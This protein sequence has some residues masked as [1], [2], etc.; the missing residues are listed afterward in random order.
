M[1][2]V[3]P[4]PQSCMYSLS[5]DRF[6]YCTFQ[7]QQIHATAVELLEASLS[8]QSML[9]QSRVWVCISPYRC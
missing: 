5:P 8:M 4:V 2:K 9:W 1:L 6:E 3:E 7:W